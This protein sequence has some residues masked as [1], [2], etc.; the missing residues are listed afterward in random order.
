GLTRR[1]AAR[2]LGIP[3]GTLSSRLARAKGLLRRRLERRGLNISVLA[4]DRAFTGAA[5][6]S[7]LPVPISLADATVRA[8]IRVPGGAALAEAA[9]SSTA[10]LARGA[11][12]AMLLAKLTGIG[13][14]LTALAIATTSIG[15]LPQALAQVAAPA[16]AKSLSDSVAV[17]RPPSTRRLMLQ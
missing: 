12:R 10:T 16:T 9:S 11:L 17:A 14:G 15:A 1:A 7:T 5:H 6:A 2:R 13:L 3:E 8:A 4:F